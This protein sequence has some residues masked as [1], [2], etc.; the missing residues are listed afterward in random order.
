MN[1]FPP[2]G[3]ADKAAEQAAAARLGEVTNQNRMY[4]QAYESRALLIEGKARLLM[5]QA[6]QA[7]PL[8]EQAVELD[9]QL[10][11]AK[12][13][14]RLADAEIALANCS[15]TLGQRDR[16]RALLASAEAI[17]ATHRELGVQYQEPLRRLRVR[18]ATAPRS[19]TPRDTWI[20]QQAR[21]SHTAN[22]PA[23]RPT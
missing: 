11:D 12:Q 17:E 6:S 13:S 19:V 16:A 8:L 1:T 20:P 4:L 23:T 21:S 2:R 22:A 14:P 10:Y 3:K 5:G 18:L 9:R 7:L 15:L